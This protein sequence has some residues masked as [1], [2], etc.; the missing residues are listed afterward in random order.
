MEWDR[1]GRLI[2][3]K[4][5]L[6]DAEERR[7]AALALKS[8]DPHVLA[9]ASISLTRLVYTQD[10]NLM[11]DLKNRDLVYPRG[12]IVAPTTPVRVAD[13]LFNTFGE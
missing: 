8:D 6:V 11:K 12:K 10:A 9:L 1:A 5:T 4:D 13:V 3:A 7:Y 2:R